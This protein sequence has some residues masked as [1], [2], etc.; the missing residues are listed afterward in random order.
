MGAIGDA[1]AEY[2]RPLID[3]TDGSME[4]LNKALSISQACWNLSLLPKE[5]RQAAMKSLG[6]TLSLEEAEFQDFRHSILEPMVRRHEEMFPKLHSRQSRE[7]PHWE[8]S[9]SPVPSAKSSKGQFPEPG[10]YDPCPCNSGKKYK[11][12]CGGKV[13]VS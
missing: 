3:G 2:A 5:Q 4:Q 11:F 7:P 6:D 8:S 12:C 1:I 9:A 10:R 13:P